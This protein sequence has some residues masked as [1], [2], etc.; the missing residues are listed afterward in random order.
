MIYFKK[1][2]SKGILRRFF[3]WS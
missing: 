1:T 3:Y 2:V